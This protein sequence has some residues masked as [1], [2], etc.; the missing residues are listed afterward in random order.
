MADRG[1]N[2]VRVF[3][4][5]CRADCISTK[6]GSIRPAYA[7]NVARFLRMAR[8]RGLVVMLA[9]ND[10]PD[11][12]YSDR[13]PC[14]SPFGGYRNSLWLTSEGH[15]ILIEYW[16]EVVRAL[17]KEKAPLQTVVYQLQQ[18][19][20]V[21]DDVEPLSRSSGTVTTADG[22]TYD[23]ADPQQ[24][25]DMVESN[26]RRG[27]RRARSAIR[28]LDPGALVTMGFFA[29]FEGDSRVVPS[30]A[31]L[32]SSALDFV[33]LHLYPSLDHDLEAQVDAIG[34]SEAVDKPVVMGE[35]GAFRV[36]F[37]NPRI[38]A[39]SLA[40][41]QADSCAFGFEG[42][43]VWL[44]AA[45]DGEVFGAREGG[46]P[47][48]RYLSPNFRP[49]PCSSEG[50]PVNVAPLGSATASASLPGGPPAH[51]IDGLVG[52][53]WGAGDFPPQWIE[54]D[55][56]AVRSIDEI[57]LVVDQFPVGDT[58]HRLLLAEAP[59]AFF[60]AAEFDGFTAPGD[61]L[62]FR[63]STPIDARYV[64]VETLSSPSWVGWHEIQV[65]E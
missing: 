18:E 16:T 31:M 17:R 24:R 20:F 35:F 30:R 49:D 58:H 27:T 57:N 34:L 23:M 13:L 12:G 64:R 11:R 26:V 43:L 19:Q 47:I 59:G 4:D 36:A 52:T 41:W 15:D 38:A 21:L 25:S 55:L 40:H 63:P 14:C 50:V 37:A 9:S 10:V 7:K 62:V 1:Y 61:V 28:R 56:G 42:W 45:G 3:I 33:D 60:E 53:G 44:W 39:Y 65:Y 22:E 51:A 54:I 5:L 6:K 29:R 48:A 2:T 32:E 46:G 8:D